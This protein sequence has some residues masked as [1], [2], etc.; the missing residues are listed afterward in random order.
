MIRRPPRSTRTD[1]LFPYTTLFRSVRDPRR[2]FVS[3]SGLCPPDRRRGWHARPDLVAQQAPG[4]VTA[5]APRPS[6]PGAVLLIAAHHRAT[7]AALPQRAEER[8]VGNECVRTC[9]SR[10]ARYTKQK[11]TPT[12]KTCQ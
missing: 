7:T 4:G 3:G 1:T 11:N 10:W 9:R 8:R 6:R 12:K 5:A 2:S